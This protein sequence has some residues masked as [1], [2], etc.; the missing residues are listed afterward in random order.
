[1]KIL[2]YINKNQLKDCGGPIG[3][4]NA[5]YKKSIECHTKDIEFLDFQIKENKNFLYKL[6]KKIKILRVF[7]RTLYYLNLMNNKRKH[8]SQIDLNKYDAI[9]FHFTEDVYAVRD[10]LM[11]FKGKII[12]TSHSPTVASKEYTSDFSAFE[13]LLFGWVYKKLII[14]DR[15]AFKKADYVIFP[16]EESMEPYFEDWD[17][18]KNI[19]NKKR[20]FYL[21]TGIYPKIVYS[22]IEETRRKYNIP[23]D[24]FVISYVGRHNTIKGYDI[25]KKM[26]ENILKKYKNVYF[27]IAGKEIPLKGIKHNNWIEVG[28]TDTP[29]DIINASNLFILPNKKTYFDLILLEVISIGKCVLFSYTGGNKYIYKLNTG[30]MFKYDTLEDANKELD[31]II[32]EDITKINQLGKLNYDIFNQRFNQEKFYENYLKIMNDIKEIG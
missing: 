19:I 7:K 6:L 15:Y 23:T 21:E 3:Y 31:R 4:C 8:F 13:K 25:L 10:S 11:D 5:I 9:H 28:W 24:A 14:M 29:Q 32:K 20:L 16:C 17:E 1:M 27:L 26:G 2:V 18:F 30:G 12:L 22:S